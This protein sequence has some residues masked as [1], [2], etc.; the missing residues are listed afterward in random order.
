[1]NL[2]LRNRAS[3]NFE[4]YLQ[5]FLQTGESHGLPVSRLSQQE[6]NALNDDLKN[7]GVQLV[8]SRHDN[9]YVYYWFA[10]SDNLRNRASQNFEKYLQEFLQTGKSNG[11][12]SGRLTNVEWA[13]LND[14]LKNVGV[15]LVPREYGGYLYYWFVKS[16]NTQN[17]TDGFSVGKEE[18]KN[19]LIQ[20][21]KSQYPNVSDKAINAMIDTVKN[22]GNM[23][24]IYSILRYKQDG[25]YN[26]V[27]PEEFDRAFHYAMKSAANGGELVNHG[28][29]HYWPEGMDYIDNHDI[30]WDP[31]EKWPKDRFISMSGTQHWTWFR[32][33][34]GN[35]MPPAKDIQNPRGFHISLNVRVTKD[36]LKVLDDIMMADGGRYIRAYKFPKTS[37]YKEILT[38]HDP[39]TIYMN[40]RNPELEQKI[41]NAVQPFVRS[42]EGLIDEMLGRGVSISPET[43][44]TSDNDLSV[45]QQ[46]ALNISRFI[47]SRL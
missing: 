18:V 13:R 36:L 46:A 6:W 27:S 16:D 29:L 24:D 7:A 39:V 32:R 11:L 9:G 37:H 10:K 14:D 21:L 43:S 42:N 15:Q 33:C 25:E 45:G 22:G 17:K 26:D 4:K 19:K 23:D 3:Q 5:E 31:D 35:T 41:V 1:M 2:Y 20:T 30:R 28:N 47:K 40:A 8:P 38:R 44:G 12:P 34:T